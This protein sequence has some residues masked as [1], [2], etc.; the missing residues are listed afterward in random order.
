MLG[1]SWH[2]KLSMLGIFWHSKLSML[3]IFWHSK[4]S[5]LEIFWHSKLSMLRIFWHS[6]LSMLE[7]FWHCSVLLWIVDIVYCMAVATVA[8]IVL[9]H[10]SEENLDFEQ[11]SWKEDPVFGYR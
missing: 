3:R 11:K 10:L 4:L 2:S 7:I 8:C 1:I 9:V 5:M 6:K